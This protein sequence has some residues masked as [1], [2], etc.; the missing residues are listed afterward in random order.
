ML[1]AKVQPFSMPPKF[2]A[3]KRTFFSRIGAS[4]LK[5]TLFLRK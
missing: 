5:K 4:F 1:G 3:K 2:F